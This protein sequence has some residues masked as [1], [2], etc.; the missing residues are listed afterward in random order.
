V[1]AAE[2]APV[3]APPQLSRALSSASAAAAAASVK[4]PGKPSSVASVHVGHARGLAALQHLVRVLRDAARDAAVYAQ[5]A[6]VGVLLQRRGLAVA[7]TDAVQM[8][9]EA[10]LPPAVS[11]SLGCTLTVAL[12][13]PAASDRRRVWVAVY[14]VRDSGAPSDPPRQQQ[15]N[16]YATRGPGS[17]ACV[18]S[19]CRRIVD[20]A[21][22]VALRVVPPASV[23][24]LVRPLCR[25]AS[26]VRRTFVH[27]DSRGNRG[28]D[29]ASARC[30]A[31]CSSLTA[32]KLR[33]MRPQAS[34][35]TMISTWAAYTAG[36]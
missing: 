2:G 26:D 20:D 12:S 30:A 35:S 4:G 28:V 14:S 16:A 3:P 11:G 21:A 19:L 24:A 10:S 15:R 27:F 33:R 31:G 13:L 25:A 9:F 8:R 7:A 32:T 36:V 23:A 5:A 6:L 34:A 29:A 17:L 18:S 22:G 1:A